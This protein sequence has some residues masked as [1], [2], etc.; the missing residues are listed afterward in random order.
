M[1]T[2]K[3]IYTLTDKAPFLATQSLLPVINAFTDK[4]GV[5]L[6][7]RDISLAGR[8]LA[9][10]P[11]AIKDN[12]KV[13]DNLA[14]LG[15]LAKQPDA[16]AMKL[17]NISASLSQLK[18]AVSELQGKGF[19]LPD[20]PNKPS[21]D[22]ER[23]IK[24]RY[25]KVKGSAVNPVLRE[26][27]SDRRAPKSVKDYARSHPHR[28]GTW[29]SASRT[30]VAHMNAGDFLASEQSATMA[31]A[32]TLKIELF[33]SDG[34]TTV[35]KDGVAVQDGEIVDAAVMSRR[36]LAEFIDAQIEDARDTGVLF[37]VHLKATMMKVSDPVIFGVVVNEFYRDVLE[38][39]HD[40]LAEIGFSPDYGVG[41]LYARLQ[42]LPQAEQEAIKADI[43]AQYKKRPQLQ[44]MVN[45]DKGITGTCTCR[46]T[47]SSMPRCRP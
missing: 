20:Y 36:A 15:K 29:S 14:E 24:A 18:A 9:Q 46:R 4:A 35:L 39:H 10:F 32:D 40:A 13:T 19:D 30:H 45:S 26:G 1:S 28:M 12:Q 27:D 25:D 42:S 22:S 41:D 43:D 8:I 16:D 37:S 38:K 3:I 7:T 31:A 11:E 23:D 17:P 34:S 6:E 33:A 2:P 44:A 47:S 5:A 21:S